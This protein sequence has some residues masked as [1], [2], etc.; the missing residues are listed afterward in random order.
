MKQI[1]KIYQIHK[2]AYE[3]WKEG[4][5][6]ESWSDEQGNICIKYESGNWWHYN[7]ESNGELIWW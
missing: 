1:E 2:C 6:V 5:P 4:A 3:N 7:F